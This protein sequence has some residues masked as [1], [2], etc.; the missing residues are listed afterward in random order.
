MEISDAD[1]LRE[2]IIANALSMMDEPQIAAKVLD[3]EGYRTGWEKLRTIFELAAPSFL[4]SPGWEE[5]NL[6]QNK[7]VGTKGIPHW[8][9]IFALWAIK[10]SGVNVGEWEIG[11]GISSVRGVH[12]LS[13]SAKLQKGDIGSLDKPYNHHFLVREVYEDGTI[14]TVDGN[15][16]AT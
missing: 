7:N 4:N 12:R 11:S 6:K 8:C 1:Y 16:G 15:S 13:D 5:N 3:D 10:E 9:G 14:D 2:Q